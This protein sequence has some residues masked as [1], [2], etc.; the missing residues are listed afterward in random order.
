MAEVK[1]SQ[2]LEIQKKEYQKM[3]QEIQ[4]KPTL[5]RNVF[6]AFVVGGLISVLGQLFLNFFQARGLALPEAG[7][8]TST[9]L[10][11]LAALLTGLGVYDEIAKFAGAGSIVPITGFANSMVAPAMEYRGEGLVLGVGARLFTVA[12][13]V[14]VFG[15]VTAWIVAILYYFFR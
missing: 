12:G 1:D 6:W 15:I 3:V 4:P 8:A 7:A 5:G 10:V 11:F 14:L 9:V 2:P 13:P